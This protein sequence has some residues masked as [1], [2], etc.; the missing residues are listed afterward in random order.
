MPII[1]LKKGWIGEAPTH[2]NLCHSPFTDTF[3]DGRT[4]GGMWAFMCPKCHRLD[5]AGLGTGRGQQ[6]KLT[7]TKWLKITGALIPA[8]LMLLTSFT[9][10]AQCYGCSSTPEQLD[11]L[12]QLQTQQQILQQQP[13]PEQ[14]FQ[15]QQLLQLQQQDI[16][17]QMRTL[18]SIGPG[19]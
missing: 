5:G 6:Y 18:N 10:S 17:N 2:C 8:A 15:E 13:P 12:Q 7:D 16:L 14:D 9:A 1:P 4:H 3:I 19:Y 11:E